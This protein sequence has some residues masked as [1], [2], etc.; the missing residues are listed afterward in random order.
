MVF[1]LVICHL[2][3]VICHLSSV[4]CHLS[5]KMEK[6]ALRKQCPRIPLSETCVQLCLENNLKKLTRFELELILGLE[7]PL[8]LMVERAYTDNEDEPD[9]LRK[10]LAPHHIETLLIKFRNITQVQL[11]YLRT[12][13]DKRAVALEAMRG[14]TLYNDPDYDDQPFYTGQYP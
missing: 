4:I 7:P 3:S 12:D 2:S 8:A 6:E 1:N 10:I 5:T 9:L 14:L 13:E 11:N